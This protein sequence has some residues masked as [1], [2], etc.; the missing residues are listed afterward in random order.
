MNRILSIDVFRGVTMFLMIWVNDFWTLNTIPKWLKHAVSGDDY[1]GFSDLIFPWFLFVMGMSIPFSLENRFKKGETS[2]NVWRHIIFRTIALIILGLFHMNMEMYNHESSLISK[3]YFVIMCTIAFFLIWNKYPRSESDDNII[4]KI[5]PIVGMLILLGSLL[6]YKGQD[7]N[8]APLGFS[9]HWWG[10]LGLIGWSYFIAASS[11]FIFRTSILGAIIAFFICLGLN[12][13]SSS[14]IA[15]NIFSWQSKDWIPGSGG[16]QA[17]TFGGV[18]TSL[19]L[20]KYS[21]KNKIKNLYIR[22]FGMGV[23]SLFGCLFL[24]QY[25]IISKISGTPTWILISMSTAIFLYI[26]IHWVVDVQR[27]MRWYDPIKIAGTATLS[28]YLIPY[29]Y[30]SFR[31]ILDIQLPLFFVT[32]LAGLLKSIVYSFIIIVI[33]WGIARIKIQLKI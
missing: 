19:V 2:L 9:I 10:I 27:K 18:I 28:C 13:L 24:K 12:V 16:L 3:P 5:L 29:F 25:F 1:L 11:Y 20:M 14:G 26:L 15:Y 23:A 22:L 7:Y 30:N 17:L 33:S 8:G 32:G 6:I 31:A 21:N 4:F